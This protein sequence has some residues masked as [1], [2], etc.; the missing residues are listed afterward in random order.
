[1]IADLAAR[2]EVTVTVIKRRGWAKS[3]IKRV[4]RDGLD[5]ILKDYSDKNVFIRW[6]GRRQMRRETR[7]LHQL[8]GI[9]GVP[10][11]FGEHQTGSGLL[12]EPMRGEPISLWQ[13]RSAE[14]I[15]PML[16]RL[17][18]L[19]DAIHARGVAHLDLRKRDNIL[20]APDGQPAV[21][22]FNASFGFRPGGLFHRLFFPVFRAVDLAALLKW[23]AHLLPDAMTADERKRHRRMIR[24]R[25]FLSA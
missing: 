25:R 23:K 1:M 6:L 16:A 11:C 21:I 17:E 12:L 15:V 2:A 4:S 20:V 9:D 13:G 24:L 5:A 10:A 22:D 8:A 18:A 19:V 3:D 14:Q 7:A